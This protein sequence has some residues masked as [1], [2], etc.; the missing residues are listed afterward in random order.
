MPCPERGSVGRVS[1]SSFRVRRSAHLG[2]CAHIGAI[3][4]LCEEAVS[5]SDV[6]MLCSGEIGDPS[7]TTN[8][9]NRVK[10]T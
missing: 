10:W 6:A 4:S 7:D 8:R 1:L 5:R 3:E 2:E 9:S